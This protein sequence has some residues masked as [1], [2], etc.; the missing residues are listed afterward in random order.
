M[1]D[2]RFTNTK[3]QFLRELTRLLVQQ[4]HTNSQASCQL[5][6]QAD[7][8]AIILIRILAHP[9][10]LAYA[11]T[12]GIGKQKAMRPTIRYTRKPEKSR[13]GVHHSAPNKL[14]PQTQ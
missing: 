1:N 10:R 4:F 6:T 9:T 14:S 5:C 11:T 3:S 7:Q 2:A 12:Y 8:R 13:H